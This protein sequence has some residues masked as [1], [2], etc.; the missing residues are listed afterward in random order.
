MTAADDWEAEQDRRWAAQY[1]WGGSAEV[2][3]DTA[4][5]AAGASHED[6]A[7]AGQDAA[8]AAG[9][10]ASRAE[11]ALEQD[12]DA[13]DDAAHVR[14]SFPVFIVPAGK[15]GIMPAGAM[16]RRVPTYVGC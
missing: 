9:E 13:V 6:P 4:A 15:L 14:P 3:E 10:E 5:A 1:S 16:D 11:A 2:S 8:A 7:S 12:G